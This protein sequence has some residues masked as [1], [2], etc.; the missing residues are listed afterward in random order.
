[1]ST[2]L[3]TLPW[4]GPG[5]GRPDDLPLPP[6]RMPLRFK[7]VNRKRWRYLGAFSDEVMVCAARVSVGPAS[8]TFWA[9]WDREERELIERTVMRFP[10]A[11][12]E[13]W[14]EDGEGAHV[15]HAPDEGSV[16][17]IEATHPE[18]GGIRGFLRTGGGAWA[19]CVCENGEAGFVWTRKRVV[20]VEIDLRLGDRRIRC[21]A[22]GVEDESAGYHPRHTVWSW[23]AGV[24][25]LTDG[26]EVGW[27]LVEGVN[28][29]PENSERAIWVDGEPFEP[30]PASFDHLEAVAFD[31]GSRIEC[32]GE[33]DRSRTEK[34]GPVSYSYRQPFGTFTGTLPGGLQLAEGMGVMES[35][36]ARW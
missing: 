12:G 6:G 8:Q 15:D 25:T 30:G 3:E 14:T 34:R 5:P 7:G 23:S 13:V 2:G 20:P 26:R 4:R 24:G 27:N 28:D 31:D 35:H 32:A 18:A 17:R 9:V 16:V 1:M 21:T 36:D 10:M 11:R 29:P 22:R 19:E 33:A